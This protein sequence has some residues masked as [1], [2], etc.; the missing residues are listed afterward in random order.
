MPSRDATADVHGA[1]SVDPADHPPIALPDDAWADFSARCIALGIPNPTA[2]RA[3]LEALYGH[4]VGVNAWLNLTTVI[5]PAAWLKLHVLDSL[6]ALTE[7][8]LKH[9]ADGA[10][11]VDLGSGGGYPGLPLALFVPTSVPW[12]LADARQKKALFLAA[13]GR[14]VGP[15]VSGRHLRGGDVAHAAPELH[16][17]C[18]LV[19]N[20]AMGPAAE[21]LAESA[22]LLRPHG[23]LV[24][25]KGLAF[26]GKERDE[27]AAK[28]PKLGFRVVGIRRLQLLE[29]DPERLLVTY[30]RLAAAS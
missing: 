13:A 28:A 27:A 21:I 5:E 18:Q 30:E 8:R 19:V 4:L 3:T 6:I 7:P 9:L 23:H 10:P 22:P 15:N 17:R 14:L 20:R 2:K 24:I 25:W 11:C 1:G 26:A 29:G 12:V 16:R